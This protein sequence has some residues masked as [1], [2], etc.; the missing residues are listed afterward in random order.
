MYVC[1]CVCV[2]LCLGLC[3]FSELVIQTARM[4]PTPV[5]LTLTGGINN[6]KLISAGCFYLGPSQWMYVAVGPSHAF[7]GCAG[8][9]RRVT[10]VGF[11]LNSFHT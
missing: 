11:E 1:V 8:A 3:V 9:R 5:S 2:C 7:A 10:I 4:P 6:P